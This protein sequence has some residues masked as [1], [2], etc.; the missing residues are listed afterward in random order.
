MTINRRNFIKTQAI[1]AAAA[2][3]GA[4]ARLSTTADPGF[5]DQLRRFIHEG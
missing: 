4:G 3:A 2:A 5:I 1:A